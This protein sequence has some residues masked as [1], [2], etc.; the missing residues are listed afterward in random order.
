MTYQFMT[1]LDLTNGSIVLSDPAGNGGRAVWE[2]LPVP[3]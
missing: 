3:N 2:E 1:A